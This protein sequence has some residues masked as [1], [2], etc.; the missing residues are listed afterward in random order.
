MLLR[1]GGKETSKVFQLPCKNGDKLIKIQLNGKIAAGFG[2]LSYQFIF[3]SN[4]INRG[5]S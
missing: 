4:A 1:E 3:S 2:S 5:W